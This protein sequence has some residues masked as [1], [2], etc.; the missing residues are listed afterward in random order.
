[1]TW[2]K[3]IDAIDDAFTPFKKKFKNQ[4]NVLIY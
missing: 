2:D 1:M 4:L 3:V